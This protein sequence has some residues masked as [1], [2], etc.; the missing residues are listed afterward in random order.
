MLSMKNLKEIAKIPMTEAP[1][2]I[3]INL[4]NK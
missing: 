1:R 2:N 3:S 4:I